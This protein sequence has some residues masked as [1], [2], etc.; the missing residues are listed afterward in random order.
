MRIVSPFH[1]YYDYVATIYGV[2]HTHF[3]KRS[4]IDS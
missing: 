1:D 3:Y 2:D 4:R